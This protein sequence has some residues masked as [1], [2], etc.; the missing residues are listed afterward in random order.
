MKN[1]SFGGSLNIKRYIKGSR[2][3]LSLDIDQ[4][5]DRATMIREAH[6]PEGSKI[7]LL[8][9][10]VIAVWFF[11]EEKGTKS[12]DRNPELDWQIDL[13]S[14][15]SRV[16]NIFHK[17]R[18]QKADVPD[19]HH[20]GPVTWSNGHK[21]GCTLR[22]REATKIWQEFP[23]IRAGNLT[24]N[25]KYDVL[26]DVEKGN[27]CRYLM[28]ELSEVLSSRDFWILLYLILICISFYCK[29]D[30]ILS[31]HRSSSFSI[32]SWGPFVANVH[33]FLPIIGGPLRGLAPW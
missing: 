10:S 30:S 21:W 5:L 32:W 12:A 33:H 26:T 22:L 2:I 27:I 11:G 16:M 19:I 24:E 31:H 28:S 8:P 7:P 23:N 15:R 25:D 4:P 9:E 14:F 1:A 20:Q 17:E 3:P 6:F 13:K 18:C 29:P